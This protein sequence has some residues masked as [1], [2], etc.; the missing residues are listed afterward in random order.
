M[1][2][3]GARLVVALLLLVGLA[4]CSDQEDAYCDALAEERE[5]LS[6]LA[7]SGSADVLDRA[8]ASMERLQEQAPEELRDEWDT[9]VR[10]YRTL[11]DAVAETGVDPGGYDPEDP[12]AGVSR[13]DVRRLEA[14]AGTAGS[15]R[16]TDAS[17]GIEDHAT[18]VCEV[19]LTG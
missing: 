16:V 9:V 7:G 8:L 1:R 12:P 6:E 11:A 17:R 2:P 3:A 15:P 4:A 19:D 5:T 13:D 14:A 18:S 10:A